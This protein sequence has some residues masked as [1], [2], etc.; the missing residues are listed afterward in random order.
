M[1]ESDVDAD[2]MAETAAPSLPLS[3]GE[4]DEEDDESPITSYSSAPFVVVAAVVSN[5]DLLLLQPVVEL[6]S[7]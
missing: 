4:G 1:D 5:N 3:I 6:L 2:N 7:S